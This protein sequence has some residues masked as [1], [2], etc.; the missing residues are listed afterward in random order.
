M[1]K[2]PNLKLM[3][4]DDIEKE[5]IKSYNYID[6]DEKVM[7]LKLNKK[8]AD[9]VYEGRYGQYEIKI[10]KGVSRKQTYWYPYI[11]VGGHWK[12]ISYYPTL[13]QAKEIIKKR[14]DNNG[15]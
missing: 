14:I 9:H 10:E 7:K 4:K 6:M 11:K 2:K 8:V 3:S 13:K 12:L 15:K 5:R 1:N